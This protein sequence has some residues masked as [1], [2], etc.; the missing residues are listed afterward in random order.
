[1]SSNR[2]ESKMNRNI[3]WLGIVRTLLVQVSVLLALTGAVVWYLN[4]SSD[5]AWSEFMSANQPPV[6]SPKYH[7]QSQAPVQTVKGKTACARRA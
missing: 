2:N 3:D 6:S 5:V 7:S 1:M 4:W